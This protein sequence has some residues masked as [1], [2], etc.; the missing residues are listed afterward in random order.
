MYIDY[1]LLHTVTNTL[2]YY[3]SHS[4]DAGHATVTPAQRKRFGV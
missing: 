1:I 3:K 4:Q 2:Q